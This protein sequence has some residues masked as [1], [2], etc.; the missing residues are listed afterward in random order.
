MLKG[1]DGEHWLGEMKQRGGRMGKMY[2]LKT[3]FM[4]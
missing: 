1:P 2:D 3:G 4:G